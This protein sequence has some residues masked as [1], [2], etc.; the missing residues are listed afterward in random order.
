MSKGPLTDLKVAF[1]QQNMEPYKLDQM[2]QDL[3]KLGLHME[4]Y[5]TV[6]FYTL[7]VTI[8]CVYI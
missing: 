6:K 5:I 7:I 2:K 4:W 1:I 8:I 3:E